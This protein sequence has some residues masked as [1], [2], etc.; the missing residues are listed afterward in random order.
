MN[1][2][3]NIFRKLRKGSDKMTYSEL[4][5]FLKKNDCYLEKEGANHE[6]WFSPMT[7]KRF[8]VG[9]HNKEEVPTGTLKSIKKAAGLE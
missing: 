5:K 6:I 3:Y 8:T 4:K 1:T 9:R 7:E 2:C